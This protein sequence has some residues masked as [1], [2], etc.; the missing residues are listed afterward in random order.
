MPSPRPRI[1]P[2][3]KWVG[4][5]RGL[6]EQILPHLPKSFGR[7]HEPFVGGGALFFAIRPARASLSDVNE[8]LIRSYIGIRDHTD[9]VIRLL[10]S[11]PY[12]RKFFEAFRARDIDSAGD[13]QVAAWFVY[14]NKTGFN[15][16]YRVNRANGFNVPFGRFTNPKICDE[17]TIRAC[18][19]ALG[20][21][22]VEVL[23]FERAS[24]TAREGDLV[25]FDPPYIPLTTTSSFT[26][27]TSLGFSFSAQE[28]LR[29]TALALANRGVHVVL[30]NSSAAEVRDLY[31]EHFELIEVYARR[32]INS[33]V[34]ARQA[35]PEILIR[36]RTF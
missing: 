16:L 32:S 14:L 10:R 36:S 24:T 20:G 25:Y 3:L 35:I 9:A 7:Y 22:K 6:V 19:K 4:G 2:F 23:D 15:G 26:T 5:K 31:Q 1:R 18:A 33:R 28:R 11:Y 30:S 17:P 8:R 12:D 29:D 27:Y 13:A 34:D 21:V